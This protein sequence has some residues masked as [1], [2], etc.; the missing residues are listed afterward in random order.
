MTVPG[1]SNGD[2]VL[3]GIQ[4]IVYIQ[5]TDQSTGNVFDYL[6]SGTDANLFTLSPPS[7]SGVRTNLTNWQGADIQSAD[8][9]F[10]ARE[11]AFA[12]RGPGDS[13]FHI[14]R[15]NVD[16]SNP[17]DA[18]AGKQTLGACQ[19]TDGPN[20]EAY[21]TYMPGGRLFFVTNRN[22]DG[23]SMPPSN[24]EYE[25]ATTSQVATIGLDGGGLVLGPRNVSHRVAPTMLAD[26][27]VMTT[28]WR[29][30][31]E[32]NEGDLII[33]NQ[34]MT[35]SREGFGREGKGVTN[36][37]LR[38]KEVSP[39]IIVAIGTARDRTFQAGQLLQ[40]NL[41]GPDVTS[42]SEARSQATVMTPDVP[43]DRSPS[44][45]GVGRYFDITPL[46]GKQDQ[47]L[48]SW[49]DGPVEQETLSMAGLSPDFGIYVFDN[50]TKSR[51]PILNDVGTWELNPIPVIARPEPAALKPAFVA[52]GTQ[53]TLM[54]AINV[55][56]SSLFPGI[57]LASVKKI[58]VSEGFST[59]EGFP[60]D[61]GL[62]EFDGMARLGESDVGSDG[63]FKVLVPAN[64]P[65]RFQM[66]DKYGMAL[67]TD[68]GQ[69]NTSEPLWIQ[70][71][72]GEAR[73]CG[74]CHEDRTKA[75]Q[76]TP[77]SSLLQ[78]TTAAPFDYP[79]L[80]RQERMSTTYT[81]D[82]VMGV[83]WDKALQPIFDRACV[84]CHNGV[85]G[86]AN[87]SYA[88]MDLTDMVSFN[89]TFDLTG[90]PVTLTFGENTY[91]YSASHITMLGPSMA[92]RE[93]AFVVTSGVIKTYVEPGFAA[94]SDVIKMLNPPA[95]FPALDLND[96]AFGTAPQHPA[97]ITYNGVNGDDAAYQLTADEY[98]LM[99]LSAD[100]GAQFYTR[101]NKPY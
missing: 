37:Y 48:V 7:A 77:G 61:F 34:D 9:S 93:K 54:A 57:P 2:G 68:S 26:G 75:I 1:C 17:C 30:L 38:A 67:A 44:F 69:T 22:V 94:G 27:R 70:G 80:T 29:H 46:Q 40:I 65:V 51:Y 60:S 82:K 45:N 5:R 31:G 73:V 89:W 84:A 12:A 4:S 59:E 91:T 35:G 55:V 100:S 41:G 98:Y 3:A 58:R 21:P 62:T 97:G 28:E 56:D 95:R 66:L 33:L 99:I 79:G 47:Y 20:D 50:N 49:A 24:D 88:L 92:L 19:I 32:T 90:R 18:A 6:G 86:A 63:S 8:L 13:N 53:S 43:A 72:P 52:Q 64:T 96:R 83:P 39:G 15:I 10:D 76:L 11:I 42:Q 71:R 78:A 16:G 81:Y 85:A 87:P 25:R 101:E 23:T 36:N 14:W 74:G